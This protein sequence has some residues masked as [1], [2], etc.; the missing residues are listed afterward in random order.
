MIAKNG[1]LGLASMS[2]MP[3]MAIGVWYVQSKSH[4]RWQIFRK[5]NSNLNA[6]L[7]EDV[8][9]IRVIQSFHAEGETEDTFDDLVKLAKEQDKENLKIKVI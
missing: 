7:H 8:A 6:F 4:K 3:L 9:G 2:A 1:K 5:K